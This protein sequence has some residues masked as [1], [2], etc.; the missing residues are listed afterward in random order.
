MF[1]SIEKKLIEN[2]IMERVR[3]PQ[4]QNT[5]PETETVTSGLYYLEDL[6]SLEIN[7]VWF[8]NSPDVQSSD[9]SAEL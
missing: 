7:I 5:E 4:V 8:W 1:I 2:Y 3:S 6:I 9:S